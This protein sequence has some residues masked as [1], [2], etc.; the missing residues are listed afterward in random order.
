MNGRKNSRNQTELIYSEEF[1]QEFSKGS[2][3]LLDDIIFSVRY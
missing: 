1:W 2:E 3:P